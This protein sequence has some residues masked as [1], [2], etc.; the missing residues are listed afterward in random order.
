M[1]APV[2]VYV[3]VHITI[4]TY[5]WQKS[6]SATPWRISFNKA[7]G[8]SNHCWNADS[9]IGAGLQCEA[10]VPTQ[11]KVGRAWKGG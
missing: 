11:Q 7:L 6:D 2:F 5:L 1:L 9:P 3:C 10:S 8:G 4:M